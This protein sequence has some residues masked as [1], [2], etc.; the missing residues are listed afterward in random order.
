MTF[1]RCMYH[2]EKEE[3]NNLFESPPTNKVDYLP[4]S[5]LPPSIKSRKKAAKKIKVSLE[6]R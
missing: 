1:S 4:Y 3:I 5:K 2:K 6:N